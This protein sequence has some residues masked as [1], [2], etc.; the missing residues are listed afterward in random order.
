MKEW[1]CRTCGSND[2][3]LRYTSGL[4]SCKDCQKYKN[5]KTNSKVARKYKKC[6]SCN[7]NR[8]DFMA[9]ISSKE[10]KC[11][12]C[13]ISECDLQGLEM[14]SSIGLV[15]ESLGIDRVDSFGDYTFD[16]MVLCCFVCNR[17]KGIQ[18]SNTEMKII[19]KSICQIWESR[20]KVNDASDY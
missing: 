17:I 19:G 6:P 14:R 5:I 2:I 15:I 3:S 4:N 9:W 12:Y 7:L 20:M 18:F 13:S 8:E 1:K 16:N 10:K 11:E